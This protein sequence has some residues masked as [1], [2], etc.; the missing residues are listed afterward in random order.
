MDRLA[1]GAETDHSVY[2][3]RFG[4][5][6]LFCSVCFEFHFILILWSREG[7]PQNKNEMGG[8]RQREKRPPRPLRIL[9][10]ELCHPADEVQPRLRKGKE[11]P[12]RP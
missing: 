8:R 1:H 7:Q 3:R 12:R 2:L 6:N 9:L 5:S 11:Q 4:A 10:S